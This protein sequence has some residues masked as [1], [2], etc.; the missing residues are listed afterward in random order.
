MRLSELSIQPSTI[1]GN[2]FSQTF[3]PYTHFFNLPQHLYRS[4]STIEW[5]VNI[6]KPVMHAIIERSDV[7]LMVPVPAQTVNLLDESV[8]SAQRRRWEDHGK[9][10]ERRTEAMCTPV[11]KNLEHPIPGASLVKGP[12]SSLGWCR[13]GRQGSMK[14]VS[15][16][17]YLL[18]KVSQTY[19]RV[20]LHLPCK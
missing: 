19:S 20:N 16:L 14:P 11:N 18:Q 15:Q 8:S 13:I 6:G 7:L 4:K 3:E 12:S 17:R 5:S 2:A 1:I 9:W 10:E